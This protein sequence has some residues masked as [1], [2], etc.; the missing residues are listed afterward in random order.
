MNKDILQISFLLGVTEK[1]FLLPLKSAQKLEAAGIVL[2]NTYKLDVSSSSFSEFYKYVR[3][4]YGVL[5][6]NREVV[7]TEP[8]TPNKAE[9]EQ[10]EGYPWEHLLTVYDDLRM[11]KVIFHPETCNLDGEEE[12]YD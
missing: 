9:I 6:E 1:I 4:K 7:T 11:E 12:A 8:L 5:Y 3:G 10:G 2:K